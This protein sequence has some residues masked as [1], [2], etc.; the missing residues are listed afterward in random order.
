MA[1]LTLHR[2]GVWPSHDLL[3]NDFLDLHWQLGFLVPVFAQDQVLPEWDTSSS[4]SKWVCPSVP[5]FPRCAIVKQ[6]LLPIYY[7]TSFFVSPFVDPETLNLTIQVAVEGALDQVALNG[8]SYP[9]TGYGEIDFSAGMSCTPNS[10]QLGKFKELDLRL[11]VDTLRKEANRLIFRTC[12][13]RGPEALQSYTGF[14]VRLIGLEN[15]KLL[16]LEDRF[17]ILFPESL[18]ILPTIVDFYVEWMHNLSV[19]FHNLFPS[20]TIGKN[21][22]SEFLT[23]VVGRIVPYNEEGPVLARTLFLTASVYDIK[24][25]TFLS[26]NATIKRHIYTS[27]L[28]CGG[29]F[30]FTVMTSTSD[31]EYGGKRIPANAIEW[32]AK[33]Y[34]GSGFLPTSTIHFVL[35]IAILA[36]QTDEHATASVTSFEPFAQD[37]NDD[38][39]EHTISMNTGLKTRLTMAPMAL[40]DGEW[41]A[42]T[43]KVTEEVDEFLEK[44]Y[45][46]LKIRFP[47]FKESLEYDPT[48]EVITEGGDSS[49]SDKELPMWAVYT[50][51]GGVSL[52]ALGIVGIIAVGVVLSVIRA[53]RLRNSVGNRISF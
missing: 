1:A 20:F 13:T 32:T 4:N 19:G 38:E 10:T 52:V 5:L 47:K 34:D 2:T 18:P 41:A 6:S 37:P 49:E 40:A 26:G 45:F 14:N 12:P 44:R 3:L 51:V 27:R 21:E 43:Y 39:S 8:E 9:I 17:D 50:G 53:R 42:V 31:W 25:N 11:T 24:N 48:L 35:Q 7:T 16:P 30:E 33:F 29:T 22:T 15:V 28:P 23:M 46:S 36:V